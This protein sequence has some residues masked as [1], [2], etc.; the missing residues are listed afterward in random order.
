[1]QV[2]ILGWSYL[3]IRGVNNLEVTLEAPHGGSFRTSMIMMPN[4]TGKTTTI[5]LLR[6]IFDNSAAMWSPNQV[7]SFR[8]ATNPAKGEF[9]CRL[10]IDGDPY[11]IRIMLNYVQGLAY[12]MTTRTGPKG[13]LNHGNDLPTY[14]KEIFTEEFVKRFIFDGELAKQILQSNNSEAER[15]IKFLYHID[16]IESIRKSIDR[17]VADEQKR[18]EMKKGKSSQE[19][20]QLR[21]ELTE[22]QER[23]RHLRERGQQLGEEKSELEKRL[24]YL[25]SK[26]KSNRSKDDSLQ[27]KINEVDKERVKTAGELKEKTLK[28]M[29]DLRNPN[30]ISPAIA[31]RLTS[32]SDKM[33]HLKL[34]RTMSRQFFEELADN[35]AC[36]CGRHIGEHEKQV[37][38]ENSKEYLAEDQIGVINAIKSSVKNRHY[39]DT[40]SKAIEDVLLDLERKHE[41]ASD[42]ERLYQQRRES[43]DESEQEIF[44]EQDQVRERFNEVTSQYDMLTTKDRQKLFYVSENGNIYVVEAKVME[45]DLKI[46]EATETV[47]LA[48][49]AKKVKGYLKTIEALALSKLKNEIK[50]ETNRKLSRIITTER[51]EVQE[52]DRHL[53]LRGKTGTSEGQ[54]LAI[55]YSYLGSLFHASEHQ[56][57]FVV[58]SPAGALD[59]GVR[60]E[61]SRILPDV[62]D[63]LVIFITSGEREGFSE[64]FYTLDNVQ[65]LTIRKTIAS[66][67]ECIVG[68][69]MFMTFQ[70]VTAAEGVADEL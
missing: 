26:L 40:A 2:K 63:Q 19:L 36:V 70:D 21:N 32:L 69:E 14:I 65:F 66:N 12:Y 30:M 56:L 6:A 50:E 39:V 37:I 64:H 53:V 35:A 33:Q 13:G 28:L 67:A 57:P 48:E 4:G 29:D 41:L 15:A 62:F 44:K 61:V 31:E 51:I 25:D 34:P 42:W 54:A 47:R 38:L 20:S 60:R 9:A 1:M 27:R 58:D 7:K 18:S 5:S 3:G 46:K 49:S 59:L 68:Q 17:I 8:P 10:L 24:K 11:T 22:K 55:A 16:R 23:L 45:I 52:I 43:A